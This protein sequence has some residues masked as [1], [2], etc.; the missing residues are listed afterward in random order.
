MT[1]FTLF[2]TGETDAELSIIEA[3]VRGALATSGVALV[4]CGWAPDPDTIIDAIDADDL[5]LVDLN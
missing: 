2:A 3:A 1:T 4:R 5:V